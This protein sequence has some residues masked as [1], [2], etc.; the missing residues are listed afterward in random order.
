[1]ENAAFQRLE[2]DRHDKSSHLSEAN[3]PA[4]VLSEDGH[5]G[6]SDHCRICRGEAA[7]GDPL[8]Y[9]CKCNGSI[10]FVH[11]GCLM[12]WLSHSQKKQCELCKTPFRFTKLYDPNMPSVVPWSIFI[13]QA[14]IHAV[15][16]TFKC[17]RWLLVLLVW[18]GWVPW[19][20]RTVWRG[21]FWIGDGAWI[22]QQQLDRHSRVVNSS[23][24]S[25]GTRPILSVQATLSN[26]G[27]I[28][29]G[30]SSQPSNGSWQEPTLVSIG[31][32]V[33][34]TIILPYSVLANTT[35]DIKW[36]EGPA[37]RPSLL[38]DVGMLRAP[39]RWRFVNDTLIDVLEGQLITILI[40]VTFILM[41]LIR[42]WVVQQQPMINLGVALDNE[43]ANQQ[44]QAPALPEQP[45]AGDV[46]LAEGDG[47]MDSDN[48]EVSTHET[49]AFTEESDQS[50]AD[51]DAISFTIKEEEDEPLL[52]APPTPDPEEGE[53]FLP[54][55]PSPKPDEEVLDL[56]NSFEL[57][58]AFT[59]PPSTIDA[60]EDDQSFGVEP[61]VYDPE[62]TSP[63]LSF[64][65]P[66]MPSKEAASQA[67]N[68]ARSLEEQSQLMRKVEQPIP[69]DTDG[70]Q[71]VSDVIDDALSP[72]EENVDSEAL[73][74]NSTELDTGLG[75]PSISK[76][77]ETI[78]EKRITTNVAD[79]MWG[80]IPDN[81]IRPE[82]LADEWQTEAESDD[83][84]DEHGDERLARPEGEDEEHPANARQAIEFADIA[85]IPPQENPNQDVEVVMVG[86]VDAN[87]VE[88]LEDG[89][90]MDDMLELI[91]MQGPL[92]GLL[93]NGMFSTVIIS[94]TVLWG[95]WLPYLM[96]KLV[97]IVLANPVALLVKMPLRWISVFADLVVDSFI[98]FSG[99][100]Y[101]WLDK[102]VRLTA[103]PLSW[104]LPVVE[105][106]GLDDRISKA[107]YRFT[108]SAADR[109]AKNMALS[110]G[111]F[112]NSDIPIFSILA[113]ESLKSIEH[114]ISKTS[115]WIFQ[116]LKE[117]IETPFTQTSLVSH[118]I[119]L[120]KTAT[121]A[122]VS[123]PSH[124]GAIASKSSEFFKPSFDMFKINLEIPARSQPL[125]LS[126]WTAS[127]RMVAV[128]L[129]YTF[130]A[131]L[132]FLYLKIRKLFK[133]IQETDK[134]A[135][136][137]LVDV[138]NQAGGV[139]KVILII[140]I[141]M[142]LFPLYCGFLLDAALLP[143]F[144]NATSSS[145]MSFLNTS[146]WTSTFIHWFTG[147]CYMFHFALFVAM[148]RK[149]LRPGVL[150]FIRD[151]DDPTFHPVRDVLE[152]NVA[153]QL[154]KILFSALVYGALVI[155][156]LGAV[157]WSI[158]KAIE[159]IFPIHWSSNEPVLEFPADLLVY[160]FLI[161]LAVRV[162]K[163]STILQD[164]YNWWFRKCARLLR[165][166][167]FLFGERNDDEEGYTI[168]QKVETEG[169][170]TEFKDRS[171]F[172]WPIIR[173]GR[174]SWQTHSTKSLN[175]SPK[176]TASSQSLAES[177]SPSAG[178]RKIF[179]RNGRLV[180]APASDQVRISKGNKTFVDI[181][182]ETGDRK[183][184]L[185]ERPNGL[186]GKENKMFS[187][188]YVPPYF[189]VRIAGFIILIWAFA[190]VTG[191]SL[192]IIPLLLGRFV[193]ARLIQS[194]PRMN[195]V[196]AFAIGFYLLAGPVWLVVK[197]RPQIAQATQYFGSNIDFSREAIKT[198]LFKG[199]RL[200]MQ[201][202]RVIYFYGSLM[203]LVP[204]LLGLIWEAYILIPLH[205][206]FQRSELVVPRHTVHFVS[207]WTLGVLFIRVAVHVMLKYPQ[208]R[209]TK[210]LLALVSSQNRGSSWIDPDIRLATRAFVIPL[211][212][213]SILALILPIGLGQLFVSY[214]PVSID[215]GSQTIIYRYSYPFVMAMVLDYMFFRV[216]RHGIDRWRVR[217]RDEVYLVKERLHNFD[218]K[219]TTS[220]R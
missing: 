116:E 122:V 7:T 135:D 154:R 86:G 58:S 134:P 87:D 118:I 219:R 59:P 61:S 202:L 23:I 133:N 99:C 78:P 220:G 28:V 163:P 145:R 105:K 79:W 85:D 175:K 113:H 140:T 209:P 26:S 108:W 4:T 164:V 83:N 29:I 121:G 197:Y 131:S 143:L 13:R 114:N 81:S 72:I 89:E 109:L 199:A 173:H 208:S 115:T 93:Q 11:Q 69:L 215:H 64:V 98:F 68:I 6:E 148:C 160:N 179:I 50:I 17:A 1:M 198:Y 71:P 172:V 130:F 31:R 147:T 51:V 149:I 15:R 165:M 152:R 127:D 70:H 159:G 169:E 20:I 63:S 168:W 192:T 151:P 48:Q 190:A 189:R 65:R 12:Q 19:C 33:L 101:Y 129:G 44:A 49:R 53:I 73:I 18:L 8:F 14:S 106:A 117:M 211:T 38:S 82:A 119:N 177:D 162:L 24:A 104:V 167:H 182:P 90:D 103:S 37:R 181:D 139:L 56:G 94:M 155:V 158:S 96:G 67:P 97:L 203:G 146:P 191:V 42:E 21:L 212:T 111:Y 171:E 186:H 5:S 80:N 150:Y 110:G 132:G 216:L 201:L 55:L 57:V 39:T 88:Q 123:L 141:E 205:T 180:R 218:D 74:V 22:S 100:A 27:P 92:A 41:F 32:W 102:F 107:A 207:D 136:G 204:S 75:R 10:R 200:S 60:Q 30:N 138:L 214:V 40:L 124:F 9:P 2:S 174:L 77:N 161:P 184:G 144:G 43:A 217:V 195:D 16:F 156:C 185:P 3:K 126:Q 35:V 183:D 91:G 193:F 52:I 84:A 25:L 176:A 194:H 34:N 112:S 196:Y 95:I 76:Q 54:D 128:V 187:D 166:S 47:L 213:A 137:L 66:S 157:V 62:D 45:L 142:L 188:I 125:Q 36:V 120:G 46:V 153:T 170:S 178:Y 210:A 206:Y